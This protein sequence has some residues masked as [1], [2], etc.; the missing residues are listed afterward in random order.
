MPRSNGRRVWATF[1]DIELNEDLFP[2]LGAHME[3]Q[4]GVVI[5][6][7]AAAEC[8]LMAQPTAVDFATDWITRHRQTGE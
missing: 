7:V 8:R 1:D 6:K 3:A 2:Q 4:G 5:G